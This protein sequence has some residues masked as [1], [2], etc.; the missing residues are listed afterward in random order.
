M[1]KVARCQGWPDAKGGPMPRVVRCQGWPDAK[2]GPMARVTR[3][4]GWPDGKGGL[5][6]NVK[7]HINT[8]GGAKFIALMDLVPIGPHNV[9]NVAVGK[10]RKKKVKG[11]RKVAGEGEEKKRRKKSNQGFELSLLF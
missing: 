5:I 10:G 1:V 8:L 9:T 2:G 11:R 6:P 7:E 3:C 4:Q